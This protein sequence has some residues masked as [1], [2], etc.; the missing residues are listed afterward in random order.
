VSFT[1]FS[2]I[3][4]PLPTKQKQVE[5]AQLLTAMRQEINVLKEYTEKLRL[6]KRGLMQ[7]LLTGEW[8]VPVTKSDADTDST[9]KPKRK[10]AK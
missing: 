7:K 1:E 6:Q 9:E 8:R 2:A 4:I 5:I 10:A 3:S